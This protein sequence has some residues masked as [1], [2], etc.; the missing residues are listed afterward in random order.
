MTYYGQLLQDK[1]IVEDLLP[2][3]T[4]GFFVE[5]G[6]YDGV[7]LSNS[8]K[9]EEIGWSGLCVEPVPAEFNNL[10]KNRKCFCEQ[11]ALYHTSDL[12]LEFTI[13]SL[14]SLLSGL[15]ISYPGK[16]IIVKTKTLTDL[17]DKVKAPKRI[18]FLSLDVEGGEIDAL[19]GIDFNKYTF[20]YINIEHNARPDRAVIKSILQNNGYQYMYEDRFDDWYKHKSV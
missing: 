5:A 14:T 20:D 1:R 4:N 18:Q 7:G 13:S 15:N 9:L 6:A 17:L 8:K 16:K 2:G 3:V 19:K 10:I 12:E 11:Y